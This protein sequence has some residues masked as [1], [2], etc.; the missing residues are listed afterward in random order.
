MAGRQTREKTRLNCGIGFSAF[1]DSGSQ[2]RVHASHLVRLSCHGAIGRPRND[3]VTLREQ[4]PRDQEKPGDR[5]KSQVHEGPSVER[6]EE[7]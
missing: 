1:G 6:C 4:W 7:V 2:E 3:G 5:K